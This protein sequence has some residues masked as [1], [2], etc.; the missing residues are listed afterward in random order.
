MN[1]PIGDEG[2]RLFFEQYDSDQVNELL[3]YMDIVTLF[4]NGVGT[5]SMIRISR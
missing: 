1:I 2:V 4:S 5:S 3:P